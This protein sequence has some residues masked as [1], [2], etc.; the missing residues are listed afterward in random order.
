MYINLPQNTT[1]EFVWKG[2]TYEFK[3]GANSLVL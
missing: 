3:N 1:G 2:K